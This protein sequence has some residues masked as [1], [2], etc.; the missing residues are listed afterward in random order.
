MPEEVV[1]YHE[2]DWE[3]C[4]VKLF[5]I[6][7][8]DRSVNEGECKKLFEVTKAYTLFVTDRVKMTDEL[9]WLIA[10]KK[11]QVLPYPEVGG[12]ISGSLKYFFSSP[13]GEKLKMSS[14]AVAQGFKGDVRWNGGRAI[15]VTG[16]FGENF[17]QILY[18]RYNI[19]IQEGQ[20]Q[21]YWLEYEH[22]DNVEI[23]VVFSKL[24]SNNYSTIQKKW[25]FSEA[26]LGDNVYIENDELKGHLFISIRAKGNGC[27]RLRAIH[28]RISRR[29]FGS[30]IP[31]GVIDR[32]KK[33]EELFSYFDPGD[34][35]PPLNVYFSGYKTQEGFE[36][37]FMMRKHKSP[38][39][40]IGEPRIEGGCCY[41]GDEEYEQLVVEAIER[42]RKELGFESKDVVL[43]GISM[44]SVGALYYA[45]DIKPGA[46]IIGKPLT[47]WGSI[48]RN[49]KIYRPNEFATSF[50]I[51]KALSGGDDEEAMNSLNRRFWDKFSMARLPKTIFAVAYM[52]EDDYDSAAYGDLISHLQDVGVVVYGKGM[53]GRHNDNSNGIYSWFDGQYKRILTDVYGR[54]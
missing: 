23:E 7:F 36:G 50:D 14:M 26:E 53:H 11:G 25:V 12:F 30:F 35:K 22:D 4:D 38:F 6:V 34:M 42:C 1:Y 3:D 27:F 2:P 43:S 19:G 28:F 13:Y 31:G 32:T 15:E 45:A 18:T 20:C 51:L 16:N 41:M 44:G 5:D 33:G 39:I 9:Q 21:E 10:S 47:N 49:G 24:T 52:I 8:V 17:K 40:L 54:H 48:A 29:G 46:V 37:Y